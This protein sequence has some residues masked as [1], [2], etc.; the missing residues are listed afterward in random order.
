[1]YLLCLL[2]LPY[3]NVEGGKV[4]LEGIDALFRVSSCI[5]GIVS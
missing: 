1:M 5:K 2:F 4:D 3:I